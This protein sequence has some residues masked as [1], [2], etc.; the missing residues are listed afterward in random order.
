VACSWVPEGDNLYRAAQELTPVLVGKPLRALSLVRRTERTDA[1]LGQPIEGVEARG[2][3]LLVHF[4]GGLSLHVHLKMQGRIFIAPLARARHSPA[5]DTVV[6]LDTDAHR[7]TVSRAPVARLIRTQDLVRDLHFRNLGPDVLSPGFDLEEALRRLSARAE[8]ALGEAL[9]DQSAIAGLGNVWKSELCF[10]LK[11]D[12]FAP[13]AAYTADELQR[14]LALAR[15]LLV[16]NVS[17]PARRIPDPFTPRAGVRAARV[18]QRLGQKP[19]S[20]YERLGAPCYD[21]ATPIAMQRQGR[22][23]RSTFFCPRCQPARSAR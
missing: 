13:V 10:N 17:R 4:A 23:Q 9:L 8:L 14:L 2:K 11:L 6:V 16:A 18:N 3:N 7:V 19:L 1:L 22:D 15:E 21:C 12:P 20:V 5:H